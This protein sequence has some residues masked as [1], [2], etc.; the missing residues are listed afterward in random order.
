MLYFSIFN[1]KILAIP[2]EKD[3]KVATIAFSGRVLSLL[4]TGYFAINGKDAAQ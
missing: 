4:R 3:N 1:V 2:Y